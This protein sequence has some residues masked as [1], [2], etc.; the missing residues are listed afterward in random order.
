LSHT[1][2]NRLQTAGISCQSKKK[3]VS[4]IVIHKLIKHLTIGR[5]LPYDVKKLCIEKVGA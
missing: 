1:S 2:Y 4:K 5:K 3:L